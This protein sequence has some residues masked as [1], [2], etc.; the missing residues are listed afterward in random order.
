MSLVVSRVIS[1]AG[2]PDGKMRAMP[3][4][5]SWRLQG[6]VA[7]NEVHTK[8]MMPAMACT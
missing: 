3:R 2:I 4:V 8:P 6:H 5:I 1:G 7:P